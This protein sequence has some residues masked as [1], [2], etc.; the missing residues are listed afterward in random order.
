MLETARMVCSS[1]VQYTEQAGVV[2]WRKILLGRLNTLLH[3][4]KVQLIVVIEK[5]AVWVTSSALISSA[6]MGRI[7][8]SWLA[9]GANIREARCA[10]PNISG[11]NKY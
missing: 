6:V 4:Q 3:K 7:G 9:E 1:I 11:Y 10:V 8:D 2:V 5:A